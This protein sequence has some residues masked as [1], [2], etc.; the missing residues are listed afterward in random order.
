M[1]GL[2]DMPVNGLS[3]DTR[4]IT[5][6]EFFIALKGEHFDG[7][8]FIQEAISAGAA[9]LIVE[10][11]KMEF[12]P[13]LDKTSTLIAVSS[14]LNALGDLALWWRRQWGKELVSITGTNGK[15]TTK[16]MAASILSKEAPTVKTPGNFNN[17]IGLPLTILSLTSLHKTA[18][19]EMGMNRSGEIR[20]LTRIANPDIGVITNISGAHLEGLGDLNGVIKA[21][22]ELLEAMRGGAIAVLN[23]DDEATKKLIPVFQGSIIQFGL[24][25]MNDVR[26]ENIR[27]NRDTARFFDIVFQE[28]RIPVCINIPGAHNIMNALAAAAV[29]H[30]LSVSKESIINGLAEFK[31]LNGRFQVV[32]LNRGVRLIDDTYNANPSSLKAAIQEIKVLKKAGLL[33]GLG[34]MMELGKEA[35]LLHVNAGKLVGG[36]G[37]KFFVALGKHGEQLIEGALKGGL[38]KEQTCLVTN[39]DEMFSMIKTNVSNGDIVFLK[40]SRAMALDKVAQAI[41]DYFGLSRRG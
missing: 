21:K 2:E 36:S 29:G 12:V 34:E 26:A 20:R 25:R 37:V 3:T 24:G 16:E 19:L 41:K 13:I 14:T 6:G 27:S 35:S 23:G 5:K 32:S 40:G 7:H 31:P 28:Q 4:K 15:S 1:F 33:V 8:D 39:L 38:S 22:A 17:L 11:D 9:G 30:C 10:N 18:V